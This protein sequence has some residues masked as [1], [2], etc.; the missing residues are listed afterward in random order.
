LVSPR[1]RKTDACGVA[2]RHSQNRVVST[3]EGGYELAALA[4][5]TV[6]H[7]DRLMAD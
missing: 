6:T 5:S 3:L 4:A 2:A 1:A 7:I